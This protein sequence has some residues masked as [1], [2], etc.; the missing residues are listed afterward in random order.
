MNMALSRRNSCNLEVDVVYVMVQAKTSDGNHKE[1]D[2][3]PSPTKET[4]DTAEKPA[5]VAENNQVNDDD[6][7]PSS[8]E[9]P[10]PVPTIPAPATTAVVTPTTDGASGEPRKPTVTVVPPTVENNKVTAPTTTVTAST[11]EGKQTAAE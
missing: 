11:E 1:G 6:K 8:E 7:A 5:S 4:S 2:K 3:H 10:A 9:K